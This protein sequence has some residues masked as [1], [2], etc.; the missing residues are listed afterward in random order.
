MTGHPIDRDC[1][2]CFRTGE[3]FYCG[4]RRMFHQL[5]IPAKEQ[6]VLMNMAG[7]KNMNCESFKNILLF[8]LRN[9]SIIKNKQIKN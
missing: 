7:K 2:E 4:I 6:T 8:L 3:H 5:R 1:M 9:N